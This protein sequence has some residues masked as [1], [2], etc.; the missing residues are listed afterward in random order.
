MYE[1]IIGFIPKEERQRRLWG[2][3]RKSKPLK[4]IATK[5]LNTIFSE[6]LQLYAQRE[7]LLSKVKLP[8]ESF[9]VFFKMKDF[10]KLSKL[11]GKSGKPEYDQKISWKFRRVF[12]LMLASPDKS[13]TY[14]LIIMKSKEL[15]IPESE[16]LALIVHEFFH[17][18]E[19]YL[20]L[21]Q[22]DLTNKL[23]STQDISG[24]KNIGLFSLTS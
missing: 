1:K 20:G 22:G 6:V 24:M 23:L 11:K 12:P 16:L 5:K 4:K 9:V 17:Y 13:R 21:N 8:N 15:S 19:G 2:E 18:C 3:L 7:P 14:L 10:K